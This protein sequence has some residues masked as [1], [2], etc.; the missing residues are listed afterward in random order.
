MNVCR[1]LAASFF[2]SVLLVAMQLAVTPSRAS[3][4]GTLYFPKSSLPVHQKQLSSLS[5][6]L[7]DW[8]TVTRHPLMPWS[9]S[10]DTLRLATWPQQA[11]PS[12]ARWIKLSG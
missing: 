12:I 5:S 6:R 1:I 2:T 7:T 10:S 11:S 4:T 9:Q 8:S 3:T